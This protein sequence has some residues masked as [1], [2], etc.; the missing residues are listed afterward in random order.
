MYIVSKQRTEKI[1]IYKKKQQ[2]FIEHSFTVIQIAGGII[3][4]F[5]F[6]FIFANTKEQKDK[7]KLVERN[8]FAHVR[9]NTK[10]LAPSLC[11]IKNKNK[12]KLK[13]FYHDA[14]ALK[15]R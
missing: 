15:R 4:S 9:I 12:N 6:F 1:R 14:S 11:Q 3:N 5:A 10:E 8:V 13:Q 7:N 2:I